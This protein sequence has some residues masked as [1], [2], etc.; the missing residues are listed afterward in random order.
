[1]PPPADRAPSE[2]KG[3]LSGL[4]FWGN[5]DEEEQERQGEG[6]YV[7]RVIEETPAATRVVVLDPDGKR[8]ES[9]AVS[10]I[11]TVLHEQIE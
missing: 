1:M 10:R 9:P 8:E 5:D 3:W 11:L 2:S 7:V 4:K 6:A